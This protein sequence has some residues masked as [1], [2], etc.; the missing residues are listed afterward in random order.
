MR[1]P[2]FEI[3]EAKKRFPDSGKAY[4]GLNRKVAKIRFLPKNNQNM[5]FSQNFTSIYSFS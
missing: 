1:E 3:F 2:E 5:L 4:F